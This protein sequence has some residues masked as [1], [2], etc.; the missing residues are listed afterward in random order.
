MFYEIS[1]LQLNYAAGLNERTVAEVLEACVGVFRVAGGTLNPA[2]ALPGK[3]LE[4]DD[5]P[6]SPFVSFR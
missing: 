3:P 5:L 2:V 4:E 1:N 6:S